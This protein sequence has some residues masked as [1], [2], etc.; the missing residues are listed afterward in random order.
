MMG[1]EIS[2]RPATF[3]LG[4]SDMLARPEAF[5]LGAP[6]AVWFDDVHPTTHVHRALA[7]E[8]RALL[9]GARFEGGA[10]G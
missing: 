3:Y 5:G 6:D 7:R 10:D 8:L 4:I 9:D 2:F 1:K